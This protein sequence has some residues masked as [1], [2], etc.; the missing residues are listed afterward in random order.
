[1]NIS[2]PGPATVL[3]SVIHQVVS[4]YRKLDA[5]P[6]PQPAAEPARQEINCTSAST[7]QAWQPPHPR[8]APARAFGFGKESGHG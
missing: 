6:P 4:E 2:I 8:P 7:Q 1:V 3:A 5:P